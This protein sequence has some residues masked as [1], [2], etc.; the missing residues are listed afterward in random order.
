MKIS[1]VILSAVLAALP[2]STWAW[3]AAGHQKIGAIADRLLEGSAAQAR[4]REIL[5]GRNLETL[6][7]WADCV[8]GMASSDGKTFT[9]QANPERYPECTAFGSEEETGRMR[10]YVARNW[11][12]CGAA[13]GREY[14]HNQYHYADVADSRDHYESGLAGTTPH[15]IVHSINAAIAV[16][17]GRQPDV[18]FNIRDKREALALLVHFVGD[19][20]QPLHVA[21]L[22]L[23]ARGQVIDP[24]RQNHQPGND[25]AGGNNL[26]VGPSLLHTMWDAIPPADRK[27]G[28]DFDGLLSRTGEVP[29]TGGEV[30]SWSSSWADE[31][32]LI[33]RQTVFKGL[34]YT[35][36]PGPACIDPS[37][38]P[39]KWDV[40]G[41]DEAYRETADETKRRQLVKAGARL[42]QVLR[43]IWPDP[44]GGGSLVGQEPL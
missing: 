32:L 1:R 38:V 11:N 7:V 5:V 40:S 37:L 28:G 36:R 35:M 21:A 8:K 16:L 42:A 14:C 12:Q 31:A 34:A 10:D 9:Y 44:T 27:S 33:A 17:Q 3:Q 4:V 15:D 23:D 41:V 39:E 20:H 29:I 24:D 2:V 6:S 30:S 25:T 26:V 19:I 13:R 22:Y 43:R 18:P